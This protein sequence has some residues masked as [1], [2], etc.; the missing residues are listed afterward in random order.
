MYI[1][2]YLL[3]HL[4]I[5]LLRYMFIYLFFYFSICLI[6]YLFFFYLS[7]KDILHHPYS[8]GYFAK[9]IYLQTV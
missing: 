6:I 5:Y 3:I 2:L 1:L 7:T 4:F 9:I 8:S